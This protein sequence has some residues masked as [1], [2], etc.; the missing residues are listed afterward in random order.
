MPL[1]RRDDVHGLAMLADQGVEGRPAVIGYQRI[2]E[3]QRVGRGIGDAADVVR[4]V[5]DAVGR[6]PRPPCR[7]RRGPA[8]QAGRELH[9]FHIPERMA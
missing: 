9:E 6:R 7:M 4:P 1:Q 5:V 3:Q 2:D 8:P